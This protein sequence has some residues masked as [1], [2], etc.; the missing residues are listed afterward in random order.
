[1]APA[2]YFM[3]GARYEAPQLDYERS[4]QIQVL[5]EYPVC[6]R[7]QYACAKYHIGR[8]DKKHYIGTCDYLI[9]RCFVYLLP[10]VSMLH[11]LA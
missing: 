10:E 11:G 4:L 9:A 7:Y 8:S 2:S 1:M 3:C 5:P 6:K